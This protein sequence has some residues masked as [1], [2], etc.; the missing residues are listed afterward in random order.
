MPEA[1]GP[2][3]GIA[4]GVQGQGQVMGVA[5]GGGEDRHDQR[6]HGL[7]LAAET[8]GAEGG[9]TGRLGPAQ[10]Q[11][12]VGDDGDETHAQAEHESHIPGGHPQQAQRFDQ[13]GEGV[14][15]PHRGDDH[16]Q[17]G[18]DDDHDTEPA[19]VKQGRPQAPGGEGK[20]PPRP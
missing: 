6:G 5:D 14:G 10:A 20:V 16:E 4:T 2:V 19:G 8:A 18:P 11:E 12:F 7:D 1:T 15:H 3:A 17:D 9:A 13:A